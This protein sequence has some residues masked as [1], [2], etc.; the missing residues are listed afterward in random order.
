MAIPRNLGNLAQGADTN[1]VLGV[2]KGGTGSTLTTF[3]NLATNVTGTLPAANGGIGLTS[4]GTAGNILVSNGTTW[5]S[6]APSGGVPIGSLQYFSGAATP[7]STWLYCS[8]EI[9][10]KSTYTALAA[11]I[12]NIPTTFTTSGGQESVSGNSTLVGSPIVTNGSSFYAFYFLTNDDGNYSERAYTSTN[13]TTWTTAGVSSPGRSPSD[14]IYS[15]ANSIFVAVTSTLGYP[16][17]T[18][19]LYTSTNFNTWTTRTTT[20]T[21]LR[22]VRYLNNLYVTAGDGGFLAT[23]TDAIT[24]TSRT[25]GTT[26]T[27]NGLA[28]GNGV[29]VYAGDGGVVA[30]STDAITWT[31][32]TSNTTSEITNLIYGNKFVAI[33]SS[34]NGTSTNGI[35]WSTA[36]TNNSFNSRN[37]LQYFGSLYWAVLNS[38]NLAYSADG[39]FW[40]TFTTETFIK[41][42]GTSTNRLIYA[43][44]GSQNVITSILW[45]FNNP[46]SYDT[47]TQFR[48]P[49]QLP[50]S[51]ATST[52]GAITQ[53]GV[54]RD[55][56][57]SLFIKAS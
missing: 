43:R 31:S 50:T 37:T 39:Q 20:T 42:T 18:N 24:W 2:T 15:S 23:S 9:F 19:N 52:T 25:S 57:T 51:T 48:I 46:F 22:T 27:I 3:V 6:T 54:T 10:A 17:E 26:S 45:R 21:P 14:L 36:A 47:T 53:N 11:A 8:G 56:L 28:Y 30:T 35:T 49:A 38:T 16:S 34:Y 7:D 55:K 29:Y 44:W 1:G 5:T 33:G 40:E 41:N 4:P 13:Q 32:R 12:G